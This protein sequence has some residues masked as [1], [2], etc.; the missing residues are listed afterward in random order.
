LSPT[1]K[2]RSSS[3][4]TECEIGTEG[5]D[6]LA[7]DEKNGVDFRCPKSILDIYL[8]CDFEVQEFLG[9]PKEA[10]FECAIVQV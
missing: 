8:E 2:T 3:I 6:R 1:L 9:D 5:V 4:G 10:V 7:K